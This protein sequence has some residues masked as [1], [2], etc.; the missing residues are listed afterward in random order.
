MNDDIPLHIPPSFDRTEMQDVLAGL[1]TLPKSVFVDDEIA[2]ETTEGYLCRLLHAL[3]AP[4]DLLEQI[5]SL[6]CR[7]PY[8]VNTNQIAYR[9]GHNAAIEAVLHLLKGPK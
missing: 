4:P 7:A 8:E 2:I 1:E 9:V 5:K 3:L 6:P